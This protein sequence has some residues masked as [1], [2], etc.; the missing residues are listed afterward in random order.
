MSKDN[1]GPAFPS[2]NA[3]FTGID[4]DGHERYETE[5]SGG[6]TLRD[7]FAA[8]AIPSGLNVSSHDAAN[9][10]GR[11]CPL[12]SAGKIQWLAEVHAALCWIM[13]DAMLKE[14]CK[15]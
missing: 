11:D 9:L 1:G 12:D 7:Y 14:R 5:P 8:K 3:V 15:S 2:I 4:S 10:V 6:M 13:A